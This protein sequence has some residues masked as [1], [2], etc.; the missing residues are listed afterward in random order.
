[1]THRPR[2]LR[3]KV[4][5]FNVFHDYP[6]CRHLDG[7]LGIL[8]SELA[9]EK[10]DLAILQEVSVSKDHGHL[11]ERLV[12]G[13]GRRGLPY[14][15]AY[16][17]ANG[18]V[19]DGG[20][21]EEGSAI[22]SRWPIAETEA[23]R[24]AAHH[25][26]K[27]E[28]HGYSYEEYRILLR[29]GV[30]IASGLRIDV[31]GT[32]LTDLVPREGVS[33]RRLQ[34]EDLARFVAERPARRVPAIIGGDFNARPDA[35]EIEWLRGQGFRDL[36]AENEP[37]HTNDADDRDLE[38]P[39]DTANQRIDYLFVAGAAESRVSV[40]AAR[41]FLAQPVE[42]QPGRFLW[43]SDHSGIVAEFD[44]RLEV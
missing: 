1:V 2:S 3:L 13:L 18:S 33:P 40:R 39:Q 16:A 42:V 8:E 15:L 22:L 17:P 9:A 43:A 29:A 12:D 7:R 34:I 14:G 41:L 20:T 38:N 23:R 37:G 25:T 28:N 5:T 30:E 32:H 21:F 11:P 31:F 26:V 10:P 24:L 44:L 19:Q 36:C 4:L 27:R 35:E 6:S